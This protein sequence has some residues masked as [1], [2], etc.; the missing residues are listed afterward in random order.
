MLVLLCVICFSIG[1]NMEPIFRWGPWMDF[2][3][4]YIIP[5]GA[6]LVLYLG[7]GL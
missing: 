4:I 6:T 3:S 2:V 7:S 1:V 5:I